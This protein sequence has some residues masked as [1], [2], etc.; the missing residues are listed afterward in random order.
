MTTNLKVG[1]RFPNLE[2]PNQDKKLIKLSTLT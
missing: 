2:L 1:D